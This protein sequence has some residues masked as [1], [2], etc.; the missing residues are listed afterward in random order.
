MMTKVGSGLLSKCLHN[1]QILYYFIFCEQRFPG[2]GTK[3]INLGI[4]LEILGWFVAYAHE[5]SVRLSQ[6]CSLV[7]VVS[8]PQACES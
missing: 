8:K 2:A 7:G 1:W 4:V 6:Q 5:K 3:S